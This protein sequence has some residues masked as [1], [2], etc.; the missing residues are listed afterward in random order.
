MGM[1]EVMEQTFVDVVHRFETTFAFTMLTLEGN[2]NCTPEKRAR[3]VEGAGDS[4]LRRRL[5]VTQGPMGLSP[6]SANAQFHA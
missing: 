5:A 6:P 4:T 1:A 3:F 2:L